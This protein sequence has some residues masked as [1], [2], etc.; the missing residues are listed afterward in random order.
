MTVSLRRSFRLL[1]VVLCMSGH[2]LAQNPATTVIIDAN[3]N[4][5]TIDARIYGVAYASAAQLADLNATLN[6]AGEIA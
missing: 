5:R 4:R 3:A 6:R 2:A 1:G